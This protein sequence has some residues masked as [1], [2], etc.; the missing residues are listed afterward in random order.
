[1]GLSAYRIG[2][3]LGRS[4]AW[5]LK[6]IEDLLEKRRQAE[7]KSLIQAVDHLVEGIHWPTDRGEDDLAPVA[8]GA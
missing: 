8:V 1:M 2:P 6:H 3:R 4:Q 7:H 5:A